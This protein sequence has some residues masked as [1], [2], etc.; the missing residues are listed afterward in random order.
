[1]HLNVM[2]VGNHD[3]PL[4][5][6]ETEEASG[7]DLRAAIDKPLWLW[8]FRRVAIPCG[9]AMQAERV[10]GLGMDI[11]VRPRSGISLRRGLVAIQGTID[12]DYTGEVR[13]VLINLSLWWKRVEPGERIA[14]AVPGFRAAVGIR[15][16]AALAPTKRGTNGF[17]STGEG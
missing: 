13:V 11:E 9:F 10:Q 17:G 4:P 15:E 16:V 6:Y 2:R 14:Q 3:L 5:K 7:L 12:A 8:P 1:M